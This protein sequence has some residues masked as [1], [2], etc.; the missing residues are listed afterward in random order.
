MA[1][2]R[3]KSCLARLDLC[4]LV[5]S[6]R[7]VSRF[8]Y[9]TF[10]W[11]SI[12]VC[13]QQQPPQYTSSYSTHERL[14]CHVRQIENPGEE[15][16]HLCLGFCSG[17]GQNCFPLLALQWEGSLI[18]RV[19]INTVTS[20]SCTPLVRPAMAFPRYVPVLTLVVSPAY[21]QPIS[22]PYG[23][24][25]APTGSRRHPSILLRYLL[26]IRPVTANLVGCYDLLE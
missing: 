10:H 12:Y 2:F 6:K 1:S 11:N 20:F 14:V 9:T 19:H 22:L 21:C 13:N 18:A 5:P 15:S 8:L 25:C 16:L 24:A 4:V 17:C 26:E 3:L 23:K 7:F